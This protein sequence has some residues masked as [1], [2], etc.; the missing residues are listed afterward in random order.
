ME[1]NTTPKKKFFR[2]T[3]RPYVS[4]I[5]LNSHQHREIYISRISDLHLK[6]PVISRHM[7]NSQATHRNCRSQRFSSHAISL[8][9]ARTRSLTLAANAQL[10]RL[11]G[12]RL[13]RLGGAQLV[14][15]VRL[16]TRLDTRL[17]A[18]L[19]ARLDVRLDARLDA[20]LDEQLRG[21]EWRCR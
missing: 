20:R 14:R 19:D 10:A 1:T 16:D 6:S 18:R 2:T 4:D 15:L 11:G 12:A 3:H 21:V 7:Q 13:A 9:R 5:H 8:S 17:D